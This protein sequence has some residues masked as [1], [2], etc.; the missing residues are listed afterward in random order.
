[1]KKNLK[2][3]PLASLS[4]SCLGHIS[5]RNTTA[6]ECDFKLGVV[7]SQLQ[8]LLLDPTR[9]LR[10]PG[11]HATTLAF[12][13]ILLIVAHALCDSLFEFL[14]IALC[15]F[16]REETIAPPR[17]GLFLVFGLFLCIF[18]GFLL[19]L[20][21]IL[22]C[23]LFLIACFREVPHLLDLASNQCSRPQAAQNTRDQVEKS[24]LRVL[25][26]KYGFANVGMGLRVAFLVGS[27]LELVA[28]MSGDRA[29]GFLVNIFLGLV[30][31]LVLVVGIGSSRT[32]ALRLS[33]QIEHVEIKSES[34]SDHHAG[35]H[36][37]SQTKHSQ[38]S[39]RSDLSFFKG[40]REKQ[41]DGYI[42]FGGYSD[43]QR[44]VENEVDVVKEQGAQNEGTG[45]K[46]GRRHELK[47]AV[48]EGKAL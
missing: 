19:L 38:L 33:L 12:P 24:R 42:E 26:D 44:S 23:F 45:S 10:C 39:V 29:I 17:S 15:L 40:T 32:Q 31:A 36:N 3:P 18:F 46:G 41:L 25:E 16:S 13:T 14:C 43:H 21:L 30:R 35:N 27:Y 37:I 22:A 1:M 34:Q 20:V 28:P 2:T 4:R 11:L 47:R 5:Q 48:R 6:N 9:G 7:P 8:L